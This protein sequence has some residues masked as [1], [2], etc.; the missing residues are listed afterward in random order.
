MAVE[1]RRPLN[2]AGIPTVVDVPLSDRAV[3][4]VSQL[5]AAA[6]TEEIEALAAKVRRR[7]RVRRALWVALVVVLVAV[8]VWVASLVVVRWERTVATRS[9]L[10]VAEEVRLA[11]LSERR[12]LPLEELSSVEGV[13]AV[14]PTL[15]LRAPSKVGDIAYVRASDGSSAVLV[16][17]SRDRCISVEVSPDEPPEV[18]AVSERAGPCELPVLR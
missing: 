18:V 1:P 11:S 6:I 10:A 4:G 12:L 13:V 2:D 5:E 14:A 8:S 7:R 9:V 16:A 17:A 15:S 3:A